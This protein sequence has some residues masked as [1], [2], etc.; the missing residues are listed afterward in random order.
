[1]DYNVFHGTNCTFSRFNNK[2]TDDTNKAGEIFFT[3]SLQEANDYAVSR[4]TDL[5]GT[6]TI[7]E[8]IITINNPMPELL[9]DALESIMKYAEENDETTVYEE[10]LENFDGKETLEFAEYVA[11]NLYQE[12]GNEIVRMIISSD[13]KFDGT[14]NE[15][16]VYTVFSPDQIKIIK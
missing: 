7:L 8:A 6:E 5:G 15:G 13:W 14:I 16:G 4:T 10:M 11:D 9:N 12:V 2:T 1:M 3:A